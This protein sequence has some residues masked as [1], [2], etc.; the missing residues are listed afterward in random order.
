LHDCD[1]RLNDNSSFRRRS[2][3]RL[4]EKIGTSEMSAHL[5]FD[6]DSHKIDVLSH[7]SDRVKVIMARQLAHKGMFERSLFGF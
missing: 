7:T 6:R 5:P 3:N 4:S 1:N 2:H